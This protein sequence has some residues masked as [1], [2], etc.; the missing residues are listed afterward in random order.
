MLAIVTTVTYSVGQIAV[1][2]FPYTTVG[3]SDV[4]QPFVSV[5]VIPS[6]GALNV[7]EASITAAQ[8]T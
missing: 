4:I 5:S 6:A 1:I 7:V 2:S 8:L 3:V